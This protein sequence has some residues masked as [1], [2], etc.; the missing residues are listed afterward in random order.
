M[1]RV[2][3]LTDLPAADAPAPHTLQVGSAIERLWNDGQ[4]YE[5]VVES[6]SQEKYT[7]WYPP[8]KVQIKETREEVAKS[9]FLQQFGVEWRVGFC[10]ERWVNAQNITQEYM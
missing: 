2:L 10:F 8:T 4:W 1:D 5:A 6:V 7:L 9:K 3:R